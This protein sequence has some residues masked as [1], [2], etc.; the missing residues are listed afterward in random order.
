MSNAKAPATWLPY[1]TTTREGREWFA[2]LD[3]IAAR[4]AGCADVLTG[5]TT[6]RAAADAAVL[7][8]GL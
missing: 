4:A 1:Y 7:L 3:P 8:L 2:V 6:R 5:Y